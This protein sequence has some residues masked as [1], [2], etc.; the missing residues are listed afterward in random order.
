VSEAAKLIV[1]SLVSLKDRVSL[2][3]MRE[4]RQK[5]RKELQG[6][7]GSAFDLSQTIRSIDDDPRIM[8]DGVARL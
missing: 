1:E 3:E 4:H 6:R 5:L 2:E 7:V 8:V